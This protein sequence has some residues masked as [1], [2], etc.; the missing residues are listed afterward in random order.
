[1]AVTLASKAHV[2]EWVDNL[3]QTYKVCVFSKSYC[4][5]CQKA[6]AALQ[7][8]KAQDMHVEQIE[9]NP[10]MDAIQ[11]YL[12]KKTGA[13]SVPRVFIGGQFLGGGDD[14]VRAKANGF[15]IE[16]LQAAGAL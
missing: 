4:P 6:I 8:V 5:Y 13:R 12:G 9:N 7:S 3:I 16:K 14:T 1:M 10:Y 15:L 11:D 2:G